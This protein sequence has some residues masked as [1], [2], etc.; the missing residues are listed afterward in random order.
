MFC[1]VCREVDH[2]SAQRALAVVQQR[3]F[4]PAGAQG[5]RSRRSDNICAHGIGVAL[6][7]GHVFR[8]VCSICLGDHKMISCPSADR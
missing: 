8:H 6:F 4:T 7:R 3:V 1:S 5:Q 2:S